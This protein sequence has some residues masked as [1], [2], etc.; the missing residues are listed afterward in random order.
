MPDVDER[1]VRSVAVIGLGL[2]GGSLA[3]RLAPDHDVLGY[4]AD[5][6]T[7]AAAAELGLA[8]ADS[9]VDTVRGR[10]LVVLAMPLRAYDQV[11]PVLAGAAGGAVVTDVASVKAEPLAAARSVLE[12]AGIRYVGGHP[13]AGTERSGFAASDPALFDGAAWVLCLEP[14]TD[15]A[16]WLAVATLV[17]GFGCR[18]VPCP[19]VAHD[20]AV[21]RVSGLPHLLA[22]ALASAGAAGGPLALALA[23]GSFRDGTRVAGARPELF[24]ILCDGNR[25]A[26]AAVTDEVLALLTGAR[27]ALRS[28][29][30]IAPLVTAGRAARQRWAGTGL[31]GRPSTVDIA[32]PGG[33]AALT[34]LGTTGGHVL[35]A[36]GTV[37][38]CWLPATDA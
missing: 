33:R 34:A 5:P 20:G 4:D 22:L 2:I 8:T 26:L 32:A 7:R 16:A 3:R 29:G 36:A 28:G 9:I 1:T 10:D 21:A 11:L 24:G 12:P 17:T 25:D 14:D 23:A 38:Q 18:V 31:G 27:D 19:A 6:A 13:M 37:L 35:G 30:T 15:L